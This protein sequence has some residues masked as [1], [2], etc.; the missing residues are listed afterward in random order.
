LKYIT[1]SPARLLFEWFGVNERQRIAD[2]YN[3]SVHDNSVACRSRIWTKFESAFTNNNNIIKIHLSIAP[4]HDLRPSQRSITI[5]PS[6]YAHTAYCVMTIM[7]NQGTKKQN[8]NEQRKKQN[9]YV[10]RM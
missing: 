1:Y 10:Q 4:L 2:Q 3:I 8:K 7:V 9:K 6:E 5:E